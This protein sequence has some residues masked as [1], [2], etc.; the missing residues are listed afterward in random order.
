MKEL[1]K[2]TILIDYKNLVHFIIIK[3]L[4]RK[5]VR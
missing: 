4:N 5:Q 1:S 2:L 3:Q